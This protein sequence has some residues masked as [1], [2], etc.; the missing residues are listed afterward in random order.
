MAGFRV[1]GLGSLGVWAL[2]SRA[3]LYSTYTREP[4][5]EEFRLGKITW[6]TF[7]RGHDSTQNSILPETLYLKPYKGAEA[8]MLNFTPQAP[9]KSQ[10]RAQLPGLGVCQALDEGLA[11][12][13]V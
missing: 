9:A 8:Q 3:A 5:F 12:H 7:F 6:L 13:R 1:R 10:V 2:E 11:Q 4:F